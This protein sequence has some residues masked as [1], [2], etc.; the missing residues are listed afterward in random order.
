MESHKKTLQTLKAAKV[1]QRYFLN[2]NL[3][4][5]RCTNG[6]YDRNISS[7]IH[8]NIDHI[9]SPTQIGTS[10]TYASGSLVL[11]TFMPN[12]V[13][14]VYPPSITFR[15]WTARGSTSGRNSS[16]LSKLDKHGFTLGAELHWNTQHTGCKS[17]AG[18]TPHSSLPNAT[19]L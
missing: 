12:N 9:S 13:Q 11:V 7:Q 19:T 10:K 1:R 4:R 16:D 2:T 8:I 6:I 18:V 5:F 14:T 17:V 15:T 3:H